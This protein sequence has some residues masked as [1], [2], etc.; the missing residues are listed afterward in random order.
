MKRQPAKL[1]ETFKLTASQSAS[2]SAPTPVPGVAQQLPSR[3]ARWTAAVPAGLG[4]PAQ[5][6]MVDPGAWS[7]PCAWLQLSAAA[8]WRL[9]ECLA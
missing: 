1:P 3:S 9:V 4:S 6:P 5:N 7:R 8:G 2:H